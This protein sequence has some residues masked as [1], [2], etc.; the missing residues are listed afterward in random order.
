MNPLLNTSAW[1]KLS[2]L[3]PK[4]ADQKMLS[5]F[6]QD[7][8]RAQTYTVSAAGITLDYSKNLLDQETR[9]TLF[10]LA[11]Q[12]Q[13][14]DRIQALFRG[15]LVN[16]TEKRPALHTA[17]RQPTPSPEIQAAQNQ[18]RH[19]S[20]QLR[21]GNW[22]GATGKPITDVVN[23][24]IGGSDLG[25]VLAL[26]ALEAYIDSPVKI[27]FI[28][29]VDGEP[30]ATLLKQLDPET[31]L[32]IVASKSF[33]TQE[34][35]NNADT[36]KAWLKNHLGALPL[37]QHLVGVTANPAK[38]VDYGIDPKQILPFWDWV[39]GRYSLWSAIGLPIAIACGMEVFL[40]FLKG[41]FALD[42]HFKTAPFS[43]N[44][45]VILGLLGVWYINFFQAHC[46]GIIPYSE[47]LRSFPN[48]IQQL[49]MESNGKSCD[50]DGDPV[51][52]ATAPIIWG[53]V[54]TNS[55]HSCHQLLHQGT[56]LAPVDFILPIKVKHGLEKHHRLLFTNCL[57]QAQAL[58]IGKSEEQAYQELLESGVSPEAAQTLAP[59]KK[60]AGSKTSNLLLLE[61]LTP[62]TLGA[63]IALY[64]HK[65]FVQSV[66][67]HINPFDQW[68]VELGKQLGN[69]LLQAFNQKTTEGLDPSTAHLLKQFL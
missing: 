20:D 49:D 42:E 30:L 45:P 1:Q 5:L 9:N 40:E 38:A 14:K 37:S 21:Q 32:L 54:G 3:Q 55:Q 58:M 64:E 52:H 46:H 67:W 13:L 11:E 25:P 26:Q 4:L 34:T 65:I 2:L 62:A 66:I 18:M 51:S 57:A 53:A 59:H 7:P 60:I 23:F 50:R 47:A 19:L 12:A 39:G 44:L 56:G 10:E 22:L 17:L 69:K 33:T 31:T 43:Q 35:L 8:Q 36:A 15:E 6:E 27:H 61:E 29:N 16:S 24:G 28:S 68:G 63:L 48:Y 41:A